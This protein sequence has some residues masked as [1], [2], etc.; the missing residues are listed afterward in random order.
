MTDH[1][2]IDWLD[3]HPG[4]T[5][6]EIGR[7]GKLFAS[8]TDAMVQISAGGTIPILVRRAQF[9]RVIKRWATLDSIIR[10]GRSRGK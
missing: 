5:H 4:F 6:R 7:Q 2:L 8:G 10:N 1:E 3:E 9:D